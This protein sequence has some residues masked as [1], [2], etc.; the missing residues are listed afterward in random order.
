MPMMVATYIIFGGALPATPLSAA[1]RW[2]PHPRWRLA[3]IAAH[4]PLQIRTRL[5][6]SAVPTLVSDRSV[7]LIDP[8]A[9]PAIPAYSPT[10]LQVTCSNRAS[11]VVPRILMSHRHGP[12]WRQHAVHLQLT[13]HRLEQCFPAHP[14]SSL[15][16]DTVGRGGDVSSSL[17]ALAVPSVLDDSSLSSPSMTHHSAS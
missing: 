17:Q 13:H 14:L 8:Q 1:H 3:S 4:T 12:V 7:L 2:P 6:T 9:T 16:V 11:H 15:P 5:H 10:D